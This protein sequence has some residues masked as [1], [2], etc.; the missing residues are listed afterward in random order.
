M[1]IS[2]VFRH[3]LLTYITDGMLGFFIMSIL[4]VALDFGCEATHPVPA[5]NSTGIMITVS[6]ILSG[7]HILIISIVLR[8]K[9]HSYERR[10]EALGV[11]LMLVFCMIIALGAAVFTK[12]DLRKTKMDRD[13]L[14]TKKKLEEDM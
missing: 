11:C 6:Q 8:S 5:N 9:E 14:L 1:T 13:S 10:L 12:E 2:V 4:A 7:T 3:H